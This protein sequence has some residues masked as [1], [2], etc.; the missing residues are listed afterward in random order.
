YIVSA[1]DCKISVEGLEYR[2]NISVTVSGKSCQ[3]WDSQTP[4]A[5]RYADR[6]PGNASEHENYCRNPKPW[7]KATPWC[8]TI[9]PDT[10]WELCHIPFCARDCKISVEGLEYRG[11][12]SV[13]V[14]G[15]SCQRWDSLTPHPHSYAVRLPGNA[16][17]HENYCR[18]PKPGTKATPWCFTID[19]DTEWEL[20]HIPFCGNELLKC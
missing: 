12:I 16:S 6:L 14:S 11:N 17:E 10:R 8:Y 19:P 5:H 9:D 2:G 3:R 1:K 13:T 20:C 4:H 15:K 7:T 18:N